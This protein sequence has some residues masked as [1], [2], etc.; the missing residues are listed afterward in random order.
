MENSLYIGLS[1]QMALQ[2]AMTLASNN[3]A[4]I[5]TPG[6]RAQNPLFEE[7]ITKPKGQTD[8]LSFTYDYAQYDSTKPGTQTLTGN[9]LDVALDGPGFIG[10]NTTDGVRY[11]RAGS[12]TINNLGQLSTMSGHLV[13]A[14]GGG[15]ILIPAGARELDITDAGQIIAD[16][17]AVGQIMVHEFENLQ[18]LSPE[19][20]GLYKAAEAGLPAQETRVK[21]G[22]IEGSNVNGVVEMTRMIEILR[23]YQS[24]QRMIQT[25]HERQKDAVS[26]LGRTS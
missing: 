5:N 7:Y 2:T 18:N 23:S 6:Y 19:G 25:E 3:I 21:Q 10:V 8:P 12:F 11:T 26:R 1:R 14:T 9:N 16:G 20:S 22:M 24:T 15:A 13:A 17:N 4:N